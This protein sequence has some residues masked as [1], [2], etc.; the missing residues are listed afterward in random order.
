MSLTTPLLGLLASPGHVFQPLESV[1]LFIRAAGTLRVADGAGRVYL[2][3]SVA[4]ADLVEFRASGTLGTHRAML[5]DD[6]GQT[7]AKVAFTLDATTTLRD[8]TGRYGELLDML[9]R[10]MCVYSPDGTGTLHW[11]GRDYPN[12]VH[13][14]LD[15]SHTAKG[16]QYFKPGT[17]GLVELLAENQREDGLV[18]SWFFPRRD[19]DHFLSSY[20]PDGYAREIGD[21]LV[22]GRQPVENHNEYNF[23]DAMHTAWKASGDRDWLRRHVDHAVRALDY[24]L[25]QPFRYSPKFQLLVRAF[26]IDSWDFQAVDPYFVEVGTGSSQRIAPGRT[27]FG[28]FFGDNHGYADAC[29]KLA[30]MLRVLG[31]DAEA[32]AFIARGAGIRERLD[33]LVWNGRF[34]RQREEEDPTVM[35]DFGVDLDAQMAMSNMY[36]LNR[37]IRDDQKDAIIAEYEQLRDHLPRESPGEWY[38]IYPPFEKPFSPDCAKWEYMNAGVHAHAAGELVR[39]AYKCG[40]EAYATDVLERLLAIGRRTKGK[41]LMFAYTGAHEPAPPAPVYTPVD[42]SGVANMDILVGEPGSKGVDWTLSKKPYDLVNLPSGDLVVSGAPYRILDRKATHGR[43][44]AA[45]GLSDKLPD[46][47]TVPIHAKAAAFRLAHCAADHKE[48]PMAALLVI[49]YADGT[50]AKTG[51]YTPDQVGNW[52]YVFA[53]E[54]ATG[55]VFWKGPDSGAVGM[56]LTWSEIRNPHPEREIDSLVFKRVFDGT[57]YTLVAL[58]LASAPAY[59]PAP[60]ESYGGPD[61]WSGGLVMAGLEEGLVGVENAPGAAA[62]ERVALSPRWAVTDVSEVSSTTRLAAGPGYISYTMTLD[63][64]AREIR[65]SVTTSAREVTLRVL[66]PEGGNCIPRLSVNGESVPCSI[67]TVRASRYAATKL[68][69]IPGAMDFL[70]TY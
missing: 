70:L 29:D 8:D 44:A 14:I 46:A 15:H 41:I 24:T 64:K 47:L 23:V 34:F 17:A 49:R 67:E 22:A 57:I 42:L 25:S 48:D 45:V 50:E 33:A 38:S 9:H 35:R 28:V 60:F 19:S 65:G 12:Y 5:S 1:G 30:E 7:L 39:G 20:G 69:D 26:T 13:W 10:T 16:M 21:D 56:G 58:T 31:R 66:L 11:H 63:R 27:K 52:W 37:G 59:V 6:E 51:L 68:P 53:K 32:D 62:Y 4:P 3:R 18:W 40:H 61:N 36:A 2:E 55:G 54:S 43:V